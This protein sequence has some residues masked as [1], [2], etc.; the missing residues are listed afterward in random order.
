MADKKRTKLSLKRK[1]ISNKSLLFNSIGQRK[2][3]LLSN[4]NV[5]DPENVIVNLSSDSETDGDLT[6]HQSLQPNKRP[7]FSEVP[8]HSDSHEQKARPIQLKP[9]R[10]PSETSK[11]CLF[12]DVDED[13]RKLRM[14]F[15]KLQ[16]PRINVRT[17]SDLP[18]FTKTQNVQAPESDKHSQESTELS[19]LP[20]MC[21]WCLRRK[22]TDYSKLYSDIIRQ[23]LQPS[24]AERSVGVH[25]RALQSSVKGDNYIRTGKIYMEKGGK[26]VQKGYTCAEKEEAAMQARNTNFKSEENLFPKS[27]I[28]LTSVLDN[29]TSAENNRKGKVA[30]SLHS[31]VHRENR[32]MIG[33]DKSSSFGKQTS[34][35]KM[36]AG[37]IKT[38]PGSVAAQSSNMY[39]QSQ[40]GGVKTQKEK[41]LVPSPYR[42]VVQSVERKN[43]NKQDDVIIGVTPYR[44]D[45]KNTNNSLQQSVTVNKAVPTIQP[46]ESVGNKPKHPKTN[47][48]KPVFQGRSTVNLDTEKSDISKQVSESS[49]V[50][51]CPLCQTTFEKGTTQMDIDGHIAVCLSMSGDDITW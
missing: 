46:T 44:T 5:K 13:L 45:R 23:E 38:Q 2:E 31:S 4:V 36:Q 16:K 34:S 6:D 49:A 24:M 14:M 10:L 9:E 28:K 50:Q 47:E 37:S 42:K 20:P 21:K 29:P 30:H 19:P 17:L 39:A 32:S 41:H 11:S 35:V 3:S 25:Q 27:N 12:L 40:A 51:C 8:T 22:P 1:T 7:R 48:N 15:L 26:S 43:S 18:D 33:C